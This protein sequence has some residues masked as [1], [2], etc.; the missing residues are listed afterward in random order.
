VYESFPGGYEDL[1]AYSLQARRIGVNRLGCSLTSEDLNA[2]YEP[3]P[4][5]PLNIR[6][7]LLATLPF[8]EAG[9][10]ANDKKPVC[11]ELDLDG[12]LIETAKG[13]P[14]TADNGP[15][16]LLA[17]FDIACPAPGKHI[18]QARYKVDREWSRRSKPLFFDVRLPQ[19]PK[20]V[21]VSDMY[22]AVNP[23]HGHG[24]AELTTPMWTIHVANL[25]PH[26]HVKA[27]VDGELVGVS[28]Q[29]TGC[30][31]TITL[32]PDLPPGYYNLTVRAAPPGA[33]NSLASR[34]SPGM[35][36]QYQPKHGYRR[37]LNCRRPGISVG[38]TGGS[39]EGSAGP[40][41]PHGPAISDAQPLDPLP[42]MAPMSPN[43]TENSLP[44]SEP[45]LNP[46]LAAPEMIPRGLQETP[47]RSPTDQAEP[48]SSQDSRGEQ[49]E[50]ASKTSPDVDSGPSDASAQKGRTDTGTLDAYSAAGPRPLHWKR[51]MDHRATFASVQSATT[52]ANSAERHARPG[53]ASKRAEPSAARP[54][55]VRV[56]QNER[57]AGPEEVASP[58]GQGAIINRSAIINL[59]ARNVELDVA[60]GDGAETGRSPTPEEPQ[61]DTPSDDT[62]TD[63][64]DDTTETP[65]IEGPTVSEEDP[66]PWRPLEGIKA[67]MENALSWIAQVM[68]C[69]GE[70][71]EPSPRG[72]STPE[73][74]DRA[75]SQR[76]VACPGGCW[77]DAMTFLP[78]PR[79][80]T[81]ANELGS[82]AS[83]E[84][85][86]IQESNWAVDYRFLSTAHFP[87]RQFGMRGEVYDDEGAVIYEGMRFSANDDGRYRVSFVVG[88]PAVPTTLRLRFLL[89]VRDLDGHCRWHTVT[90]PPIQV[91][92]E[93]DSRRRHQPGIWQI[94]HC[95]YSPSIASAGQYS[96]AEIRREGTAR[97]G[98]G[99]STNR[100]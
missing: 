33:C 73:Q 93:Q 15:G 47:Q 54:K 56:A 3:I 14:I 69:D 77:P 43:E 88:T 63:E 81:H 10:E 52:T 96:I 28:P 25:E 92:P 53:E 74:F 61:P 80:L 8:T 23:L 79:R 9:R 78:V 55:V 86:P 49:P 1:G 24:I 40:S 68:G 16:T 2:S 36:V 18:V 29:L 82:V 95:G 42:E 51:N 22:D 20:I 76:K 99:L 39:F 21:A 60:I 27:Y 65:P 50:S 12:Q 37:W 58:T 6:V 85:D 67:G 87:R 89:H 5:G 70:P 45:M 7:K 100:N 11:V 71:E 13:V 17:K 44:E 35:L 41:L 46:P 59:N 4:I 30:E 31:Q 64:G 72:P 19:T 66:E 34:P 48:G 94:R 32:Q 62:P 98:F 75:R 91:Q 84:D 90:L 26:S 38:D 97:F 83:T 57:A